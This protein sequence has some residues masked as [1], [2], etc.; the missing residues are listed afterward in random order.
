MTA[1]LGISAFYHD[2]AAALVVDGKL[3]AAAQEE[4]FSRIKHDEAF[5]ARAIEWCLGEAGLGAADLDY[6]GFYDKPYLKFERI[7]ESHLASA[8][9]SF[10][11][12]VKAMP[13]WLKQK[14]WLS[15]EIDRGLGH[16]HGKKII[17]I[18]HHESHAASAFFPSPFEDAA[19]LT[20]DGVGEWS[21]S[22]WGVGRG[23]RIELS[24]ALEFPHSLGL[25]YTAFTTYAG[26]R[27]N[28]D[29]YK[30]MGLAPYGKPVF[31][32][33]ILEKL[34]DLRAD[35]SF[36]IDPTYFDFVGG[37]R[38]TSEKFH[39]LF[40]GPPRAVEA[41]I[42]QIHMD[43][44]ASIQ[45]V[46]EEIVLRAARFVHGET[47]MK[48]LCLS[49]GVALNCVVNGRLQREGP[50]D[51]LWIQPAAGDAGGALGVALFVW[52]QLLDETRRVNA[53]DDA[54]GS[55]LGSKYADD[56]I[57][58]FL[59]ECGATYRLYTDDAELTR[60]VAERLATGDVVGWFQGRM[61]FGPRALGSRS[62]L[63]DP[64]RRE[65]QAT[66]NQKVKFREGFR[67]FAPAVLEE[68]AEEYFALAR[69]RGASDASVES[70]YMLIVCP[71]RDEQLLPL[72]A[73]DAARQGLDRLNVGRSKLP[74]VTHVDGSARVQTV[75]LD[76]HGLY[77]RLLEEFHRQTGCPVLVN[78]SFNLSWEPIVESPQQAY[79]TFMSS[80]LDT[81]CLGHFVLRKCEQ[82]ASIRSGES[83]TE[84]LLA[85]V[86]KSP[87]CGAELGFEGDGRLVCSACS[88]SFPI[89]EGIAR[90]YWP[91][92]AVGG[93]SDVTEDVK[94]FYEETPFPN[95]DE[96]DS[97]RSLIDKSRAGGYAHLLDVAIPHNSSVLE[98]GCGTGQLSNFL[99]V[100]CRRVVGTDL[101][102]N[103]L[104]LA[105]AFREK[106]GLDRVQFVQMNLFRP[107]F[108][109][110]RFDVILCNGVL[111]HTS[112]PRGGF[113]GLVPLLKP[114]G[115]IVIG[116]YN[117]WGRS[118]TD[119]RRQVF[120]VTGGRARWIDPYLRGERIHPDK[121]RA[122]FADQYRHPHE[123]KHTIDEVLEW[124]DDA[125]LD[126]VRG[127]P[128]L[129]LGSP[130][131][132]AES[133]FQPEPAGTRFDHL[134]S[135][136]ATIRTGSREGGFFLM[137]GRKPTG[138]REGTGGTGLH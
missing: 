45:K 100:G 118:M 117:R 113:H 61:E 7:L 72:S 121:E 10:G 25:L 38:M 119:L 41:A 91:H 111:H 134:V 87:C 102:L 22:T 64:R 3:V 6:V 86:S 16:A 8:P 51:R 34:I 56:T 70:P 15:R 92:E 28:A 33:Q 110:E 40:G 69:S 93:E 115:T 2:S 81:L 37:L 82:P 48:N 73:A 126:L 127:V 65:M 124:F 116:L 114:G 23:N 108:A 20:F 35:G 1:I 60:H 101:C 109:G 128:A 136:L 112:D 42:E 18:E 78:T 29:E 17:Y 59:D 62:I 137:I 135:Q 47:G 31:Y 79:H 133:L 97:V 57:R 32:D 90:L 74:A 80:D 138:D 9:R 19:I 105:E 11:A 103:S 4:R 76:R 52:H 53:H 132:R 95:Y 123:S 68:H 63:A 12:F 55:L 5:P 46:V 13:I 104:R 43:L 58:R 27:A 98:V 89:E 30:L 94:A 26:F 49:G 130:P 129:K 21:T 44:A 67:P 107:A 71:V 50:F 106:H 131:L 24:H 77:R 54:R 99:G 125:G 14:L 122:W 96:H 120:R 85:N 88:V 66:I 39:A 36:R 84:Q 83:R 75:D